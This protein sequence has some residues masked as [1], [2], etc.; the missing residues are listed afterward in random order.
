MWTLSLAKS[1]ILRLPAFSGERPTSHLFH[2]MKAIDEGIEFSVD[3]SGDDMRERNLSSNPLTF[4]FSKADGKLV[5]VKPFQPV[6]RIRDELSQVVIDARQCGAYTLPSATHLKLTRLMV[7]YLARCRQNPRAIV[8]IHVGDCYEALMHHASPVATA[9]ALPISQRA[10]TPMCAVPSHLIE[11]ARARL[12]QLG[13][14]VIL[15]EYKEP[16][17]ALAM[18]PAC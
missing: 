13:H 9:L 10:N 16:G 18:A 15:A 4:R 5:G 7:T 12:Q 17:T 2:P 6:E 8:L 1:G 3:V 14:E 11:Y